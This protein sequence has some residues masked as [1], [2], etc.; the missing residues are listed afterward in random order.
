MSNDRSPFIPAWLD[1]FGLRPLPF[2]VFCHLWRRRSKDGKCY[3]AE[4]DIR[5][6]CRIAKNSVWSA[7]AEL[8]AVGLLT[9]RRGF[10]NSNQYTLYCKDTGH[11]KQGVTQFDST[12]EIGGD[13]TPEAGGV[14]YT[15]NRG[16][17]GTP[18]K[19]LH[20][21]ERGTPASFTFSQADYQAIALE[22]KIPVS[23]AP[24]AVEKFQEYKRPYPNDPQDRYA[25]IQWLTST[26]AGKLVINEIRGSSGG[27]SAKVIPPEPA[28][29]RD[30]FPDFV[31]RDKAWH[32]L[33]TIQQNFMINNMPAA[34]S[35]VT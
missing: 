18:N 6:S 20:K 32:Q 17:K 10:G 2:R 1:D 3:P 33:D 14:Q 29:W 23:K 8:E 34:G 15:Q 22:C 21:G 26:K 27:S 11:P 25:V 9:R 13:S 31:D 12:P 30:E 7:I 16:L 5:T 4:K 24:L 35:L 19:V 28:G